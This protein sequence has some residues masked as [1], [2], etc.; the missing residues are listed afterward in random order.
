MSKLSLLLKSRTFWTVAVVF[1]YN[2]LVAVTGTI[3]NIPWLSDVINILG[4]VMA[5][6]FH[7]NPSQNYNG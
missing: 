3:P 7:V 4:L 2:G 1:V 5:S 6:Y